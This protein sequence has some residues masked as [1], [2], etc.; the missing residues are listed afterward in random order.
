[1]SFFPR[2]MTSPELTLL[3]KEG[4]WHK[5][6][7]LIPQSATV[8]TARVN[9]ATFSDPLVQIT[10]DGGS[11][12]LG[13][14]I[15]GMTVL[16]G[17]AAGKSDKGIARIR[18]T[19]SATVFYINETSELSGLEDNDYITILDEFLPWQRH[20]VIDGTTALMDYDVA[21]SDQHENC[22]PVVNMGSDW[23][24]SLGDQDDISISPDA[25]ESWVVGSTV[26]SYLWVVTG[27]SATANLD[28]ATPTITYDTAGI[29]RISCT[30]T[31]ANSKARTSYRYVYIDQTTIPASVGNITGEIEHGG[32]S[33]EVTAYDA[34]GLTEVRDRSKCILIVERGDGSVLGYMTGNENI[35]CTGWIE[36]ESI[37]VSSEYSEV[38]LR[39]SGL[40]YWL[41]QETSYPTGIETSGTPTAWTEM[42]N[43]TVDKGLWHL[44]EWRT[45][46]LNCCDFYPTGDTKLVPSL[47]AQLGT[48][49]EQLKVFAYEPLLAEITS[50]RYNRLFVKVSSQ[51][52]MPVD[53]DFPT[54]LSL[55]SGDWIADIEFD[56]V[57]SLPTTQVYIS[58]IRDDTNDPLFSKAPGKTLSRLGLMFN[59]DRLL[60]DN[61]TQANNLSGLIYARLNNPYKILDINLSAFNPMIDINTNHFV[62]ITVT[63]SQNSREISLTNYKL[64]INRIEHRFDNT[65]GVLSTTIECEGETGTAESIAVNPGVTI[66]YPEPMIPAEP[67]IE[68][69]N[70]EDY[71]WPGL[72]PGDWNYNPPFVPPEPI[73]PEEEDATCPTDAPANG[74]YT[75]TLGGITDIS[76]DGTYK[77]NLPYKAVLRSSSH[78]NKSRYE[79][80]GNFLKWDTDLN[81][82]VLDEDDSFYTVYAVTGNTVVTGVKDAVTSNVVRSGTFNNVDSAE[83]SKIVVEIIGAEQTFDVDDV[84]DVTSH[85]EIVTWGKWG[86]GVWV[87]EINNWEVVGG[88]SGGSDVR[89]ALNG[90]PQSRKIYYEHAAR[91]YLTN[92]DEPPAWASWDF[93]KASIRDTLIKEEAYMLYDTL[94]FSYPVI[95]GSLNSAVFNSISLKGAVGVGAS[96]WN[97][98]TIH[99]INWWWIRPAATRM[100]QF[101]SFKLY[102]VCPSGS[103]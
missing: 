32:W 92:I 21:Y 15:N 61:Q 37:K 50:D 14:V 87:H 19:P 46:A 54:I 88:T 58:G 26:A 34:V 3:R 48:L 55:Q 62:D 17:S 63:T 68:I 7:V 24:L 12:T 99:W 2:A 94:E 74:P 42:E 72:T 9:Q 81:A 85:D 10:Y 49:W 93:Y 95:K 27:A 40:N 22:L 4:V 97:A 101:Y 69:P 89:V 43:L 84:Y 70:F 98:Y 31:G 77:I 8:Y 20:L 29:Y 78:D 91:G 82:W 25:S 73:V 13:D 18:K 41:G 57:V 83:I 86:T 5:L 76:S 71:D 64:L 52:I 44:M 6:S 75:A 90:D 45:T 67:G 53:R 30:V 56:R 38:K 33:F 35:L 80:H 100:I 28:T 102:N 59:Q 65:N 36:K 66:E 60:L 23:V 103:A 79:I 11:G 16:F 96:L 47:S 51:L 1:M 39:V